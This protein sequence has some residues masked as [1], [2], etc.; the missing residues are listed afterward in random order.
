MSDISAYT[1]RLREIGP[2][3]WIEGA[4]G[5]TGID[6]VSITLASWQKVVLDEWWK[7]RKIVS[8]VGISNIKKTGKTFINGAL[9]AWRWLALP[10]LHFCVA[11]DLDQSMSRQFQE[12]AEMAKRN[13]FLK[14][15]VRI[16]KNIIEFIPT[17]SIIQALAGDA[18]GNAG[19][20][21]LTVSFTELWGAIN[22]SDIRNFEELTT[23]PGSFFG[24]P[25]LRV[26]DSYAGWLDESEVWHGL[27][28]QG[29]SGERIKGDWP[30]Y[31]NG[32]LLLFHATGA[33]AQKKCFRGTTKEA[34]AYYKD[35]K[36]VLRENSFKR[37]HENIRTLN[38]GN[39]VDQDAWESLIDKELQPLPAG[40]QI[41]VYVGL[42]L[43]V[44]AGGDNCA[45]IGVYFHEGK[46]KVA[47][48]RVWKGG[49][50]RIKK[51]NLS[52][53]VEPFILD[54]AQ[55]Y[56]IEGVYFD[57][58]QAIHL[59]ERLREAGINCVE[60]SQTHGSRGPK[61]T[62]LYEMA[63]N[64]T[65]VLFND[66]ELKNMAI[67]ANAKELGNG[68]LFLQ[69]AGRG[70]IDLLV[71]L[72]NCA[73]TCYQVEGGHKGKAR[74]FPNIFYSDAYQGASIENDFIFFSNGGFTFAPNVNK[75]PHPEGVTW[76]N[77]RY[78]ANGCQACVREM[79]LERVYEND[80]LL[81]EA[82]S[83]MSALDQNT[84]RPIG[85]QHD[86]FEQFRNELWKKL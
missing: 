84:Y 21:F 47:F 67:G 61:D 37:L 14:D 86:E 72:S 60:V 3:L 6:G 74:S 64:G 26:C 46:V 35:Q 27:V 23:P 29:L 42:D 58:W 81:D 85:G 40:S 8:T 50:L 53:S 71:A 24:L 32:G 1:E 63:V 17:G 45:L 69:K 65:L 11:N 52:E 28:D 10:G 4:Y 33:F 31:Q 51:L 25:A 83:T 44:A 9:L 5:W 30:L 78:R 68:M 36:T 70:K 12:I 34:D 38:V 19:A 75:R 20:N 13:Q 54:L 55:N 79:E 16:T 43:A 73:D 59:A 76:R 22:E 15:K 77:C 18:S 62:A 66:T 7:R 2:A 41:P 80:R 48:Y 49:K 82:R 56:N 39:F 57:P